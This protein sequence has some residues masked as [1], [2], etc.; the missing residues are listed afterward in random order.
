[1]VTKDID[2]M[3]YRAHR[4]N[5]FAPLNRSQSDS[6]QDGGTASRRR[7]N[8]KDVED[9]TVP[10]LARAASYSKE[11]KQSRLSSLST[12]SVTSWRAIALCWIPITLVYFTVLPFFESK[13]RIFRRHNRN[14]VAVFYH[15]S[16]EE[17]KPGSKN[18]THAEDAFH[19]QLAQV[20]EASNQYKIPMRLYYSTYTSTATGLPTTLQQADVQ[21]K[22]RQ[23]NFKG[24]CWHVDRVDRDVNDKRPVDHLDTLQNLY[25][26]CQQHPEQI[27]VY[28][29]NQVQVP[30]LNTPDQPFDIS[31]FHVDTYQ[32]H[33]TLAAL[34]CL[35]LLRDG[36][37]AQCDTCGLQFFTSWTWFYPGN[38][39]SA[40]CSY[41]RRLLP[42][43]AFHQ[44]SIVLIQKVVLLRF[45]RQILTNSFR[46]GVTLEQWGLDSHAAGHWLGSHPILKPCDV[47]VSGDV[48]NWAQKE[49]HKDFRDF[50]VSLTPRHHQA[51]WNHDA[52]A[53]AKINT[54]KPIR[55][56]EYFNH[57]AGLLTKWSVWYPSEVPPQS[58]WVWDW[59]EDGEFWKRA[60]AI[61]GTNAAERV[62][63]GYV[64]TTRNNG[65]SVVSK[66]SSTLGSASTSFATKQRPSSLK[67]TVADN[68]D[69]GGTG[70]SWIPPSKNPNAKPVIF[71][72]IWLPKE[73]QIAA[74]N[75]VK[76]Q[77]GIIESNFE[78]QRPVVYYNH[79]GDG[80]F[81][82]HELCSEY[83]SECIR[84]NEYL[85][86]HQG[87]LFISMQNYCQRYPHAKV[88]YIS[89]T[90]DP[91]KGNFTYNNAEMLWRHA[92]K[93]ATS[94]KCKLEPGTCNVCGLSFYALPY[95]FFLGHM[96]TAQ[97]SYV[98]DLISPREFE[99]RQTDT[100][101]NAMVES[102]RKRFTTSLFPQM[103]KAYL[104][105]D[106][107]A[108]EHWIGSHPDVRPCDLTGQ[109]A[110]Y[111]TRE[112]RA[113][114]QFSWATAP[115]QAYVP[116]LDYP[117]R[118]DWAVELRNNSKYL[119]LE[120]YFM[121]GLF[122][123]WRELY[124]RF[125]S[126]D[127]WVYRWF[128]EG[129]IFEEAVRN[130][131]VKSAL[132]EVTKEFLT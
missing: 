77:L 18:T 108:M 128:P 106:E 79:L 100:A 51:P 88:S 115:R 23:L 84:L 72:N 54:D 25:D 113:P 61:Y 118:A 19:H 44:A 6:A 15:W 60:V 116:N 73:Q 78:G 11:S 33:L 65:N 42:P 92:T 90:V 101:S 111:W 34:S 123:R 130:Y 35:Q 57:M 1:L 105:V 75:R 12:R 68:T 95:F 55:L 46:D 63:L 97:C 70:F 48:W 43:R 127:S 39:W 121:T 10:S 71:Y 126:S 2:A 98:N 27:V 122:Y 66:G 86:N 36:G 38:M 82:A 52:Q 4:R 85:P 67:R 21:S 129:P 93:A 28:L 20:A 99:K 114:T 107:F 87:E 58:S 7:A 16:D 104:G 62:T 53:V 30:Q 124:Q 56:R 32:R 47:S 91:I 125:P 31:A 40:H 17:T 132:E 96:W 119:R 131:G 13:Y 3:R 89:N 50:V 94:D 102:I 64:E 112:E 110:D 5:D 81:N 74:V 76:K 45:R 29:H 69:L 22:C 37:S 41:V 49:V 109:E 26:F 120:Y 8:S 14:E 83:N 80:H 117:W 24:S 9:T 59:F 103:N